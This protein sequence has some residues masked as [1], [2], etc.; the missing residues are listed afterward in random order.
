MADLIELF[1]IFAI[2]PIHLS[3]TFLQPEIPLQ[4]K[5]SSNLME[6]IPKKGERNRHHNDDP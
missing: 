5:M 4:E 3:L 1:A 6:I 2:D